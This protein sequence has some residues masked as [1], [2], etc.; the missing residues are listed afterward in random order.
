MND[1]KTET[2]IRRFDQDGQLSDRAAG[3]TCPGCRGELLIGT[4]HQ[5]QFAGCPK[6]GGMLFQQETFAMMIAHLRAANPE[7][8]QM[9]EPMDASQLKVR[10]LCPTCDTMLETHPYAGP[11]NSVID[12][13]IHCQVIWFD[14]G[15]L[16]KL[17]AAPGRR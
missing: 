7:P 2:E 10:R 17:V 6:C 15:E 4:L 11:G 12:T 5:C 13:C 14:A 1:L 9:P 16:T 3:V 8:A